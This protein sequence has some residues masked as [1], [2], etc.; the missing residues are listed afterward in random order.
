MMAIAVVSSVTL[1]VVAPCMLCIKSAAMIAAAIL[2]GVGSLNPRI[3]VAP[4]ATRVRHITIHPMVAR[5]VADRVVII[6]IAAADF[7]SHL[8]DD[9]A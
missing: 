1:P 2:S 6:L 9:D 5:M 8:V 7:T 4:R 3:A